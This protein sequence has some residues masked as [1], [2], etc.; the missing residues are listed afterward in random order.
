[1]RSS[2]RYQNRA[3]SAA[4]PT[5]ISRPRNLQRPAPSTVLGLPYDGGTDG[6]AAVQGSGNRN[7]VNVACADHHDR[8]DDH[9]SFGPRLVRAG[10][11]VH[12]AVE[13]HLK[14][15]DELIDL[16]RGRLEEWWRASAAAWVNSRAPVRPLRCLPTLVPSILRASAGRATS[17]R[18]RSTANNTDFAFYGRKTSLCYRITDRRRVS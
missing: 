16:A 17:V 11:T 4:A 3:P 12:L 14:V 15:P 13:P 8:D 1:M 6:T 5:E 9:P 2:R 10:D 7:A 18:R